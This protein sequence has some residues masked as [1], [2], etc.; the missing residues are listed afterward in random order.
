MALGVS[1]VPK[2]QMVWV[3]KDVRPLLQKILKNKRPA[4]RYRY[5]QKDGKTVWIMNEIGKILPITMAITIKNNKLLDITVLEYRES[6]GSEIKYSSFR[7]QFFDAS[8]KEN[9]RLSKK[10]NGI[11]GATLSVNT[12]KRMV[13]IALLL[14]KAVKIKNDTND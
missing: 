13:R 7:D 6:H 3:T 8:I 5:W 10:I 12:S 9:T 2:A 1:E 14:H 4:L 11:S